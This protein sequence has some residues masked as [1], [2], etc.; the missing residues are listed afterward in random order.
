[1]DGEEPPHGLGQSRAG[2]WQRSHWG[3]ATHRTGA[4]AE[5]LSHILPFFTQQTSTSP[6]S[7]GMFRVLATPEGQ[8]DEGPALLM[9]PF[10]LSGQMI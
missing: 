4:G 9:L 7:S 8:T 1:M 2:L 3:G 5:M 10:T 6:L